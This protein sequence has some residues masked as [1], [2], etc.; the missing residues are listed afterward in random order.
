MNKSLLTI[1]CVTYNH[2]TYIRDALDGFVNQITNFNYNVIVYDDAST[3]GTSDIILE[4]KDKYPDIF[5]IY[6]ATENTYKKPIREKV[7]SEL[8]DKYLEGKYMAFCEGDDY[9]TDINKLQMQV[10]FLENNPD[11]VMVG[12][13][14]MIENC[15]TGE[16]REYRVYDESR[17]ITPDEIIVQYNGNIPTASLV[18]RRDVYFYDAQFPKCDVGDWPRQLN[19][20]GKG[21]IYYINKIMSTYRYMAQGSWT[22]N[23]W[24]QLPKRIKHNLKMV[25]FIVRYNEYSEHKYENSLRRK[26]CIYL[27]SCLFDS[28]DMS[29]K[30]FMRIYKDSLKNL[31]ISNLVDIDELYR[32]Y[33]YIKGDYIFNEQQKNDL[34]RYEYILIMGHGCYSHYIKNVLANNQIDYN[35]FVVTKISEKEKISDEIIYS[36]SD[37]P[38]DRQKTL[39]IIGISQINDEEI[40]RSLKNE[41]FENIYAPMW[42]GFR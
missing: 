2:V 19:A 35:G 16:K 23:M 15:M 30:Q 33:Q 3:D 20:L 11:C 41:H 36:L 24:L 31:D 18:M 29:K 42:F 14:A 27:Y 28:G 22:C 32:V 10:D 12:H 5:D 26:I 40:I 38:Y 9:W 17:Y 7:L 1:V 34:L 37:W 4:Y 6:I 25:D 21:K 13:S 8:F 39:V